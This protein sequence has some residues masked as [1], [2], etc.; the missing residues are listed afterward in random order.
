MVVRSSVGNAS[1]VGAEE[2]DTHTDDTLSK[3]VTE[4]KP[5]QQNLHPDAKIKKSKI[6]L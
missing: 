5:L 3:P 4:R 1:V 6:I 2:R